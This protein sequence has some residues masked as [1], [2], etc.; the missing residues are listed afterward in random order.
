MHARRPDTYIARQPILDRR[1]QVVAY[2]L[3]FR[4]SPQQ[5]AICVLDDTA[6]TERLVARAFGEVGLDTVVGRRRAFINVNA[7]LLMSRWVETL[8]RRRVVLE[9][10]ESIEIDDAIVR[11][12][13]DLHRRGFSLALDDVVC[14]NEAYAPLLDAI[15]IVKVDVLG[16]EAAALERLVARLQGHRPRLLAEKVE[17]VARARECLA[18]GFDRFQGFVFGRPQVFAA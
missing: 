2:E 15:D 14:W 4:D 9:L 18:L 5:G 10:L 13:H 6:A 16:M 7:E 12:C 8:P 1:G 11:R 17:S 3:L